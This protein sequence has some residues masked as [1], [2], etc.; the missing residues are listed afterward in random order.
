MDDQRFTFL[1]FRNN[2]YYYSRPVPLGM[3]CHYGS[4]RIVKSLNARFKRTAL[5]GS[6]QINFQLETYWCSIR[7]EQ[8]AKGHVS[9]PVA[10]VI[11]DG[12]GYGL[13]DARDN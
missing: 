6:N 11:P 9:A 4:K 12:C 8:L 13:L 2:T 7:V 3:K 1:F 10:K 5:R